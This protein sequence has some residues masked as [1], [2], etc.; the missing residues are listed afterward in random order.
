M[1]TAGL[2]IWFIKSCAGE[3]PGAGG[4]IKRAAPI[5]KTV[6]ISGGVLQYDS[7]RTQ[8]IFTAGF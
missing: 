7:R 8:E 5:G 2:P 6:E 4:R 3:K 1:Y